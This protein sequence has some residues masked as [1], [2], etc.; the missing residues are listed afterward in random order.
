MTQKSTESIFDKTKKD[1]GINK[2]DSIKSTTAP[3]TSQ[4]SRKSAR[5]QIDSYKSGLSHIKLNNIKGIREA[6]LLKAQRPNSLTGSRSQL[7]PGMYL[8]ASH[9]QY[10]TSGTSMY[11]SRT[12][13]SLGKRPSIQVQIENS[14]K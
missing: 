6:A 10:K 7:K 13:T 8:T 5:T 9:S 11:K 2:I 14:P 12:Q 1:E 3:R 4:S